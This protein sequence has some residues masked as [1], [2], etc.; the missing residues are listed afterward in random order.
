MEEEAEKKAPKKERKKERK[1]N[2]K[3][4]FNSKL[5]HAGSDNSKDYTQQQVND[6]MENRAFCY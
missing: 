1:K 6:T 5:N 2:Q 3:E 4:V